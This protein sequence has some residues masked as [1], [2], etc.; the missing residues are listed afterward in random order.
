MPNTISSNPEGLTEKERNLGNISP[1]R[2]TTSLSAQ[3]VSQVT[4]TS[5]FSSSSAL[6]LQ[7][8]NESMTTISHLI[9]QPSLPGEEPRLTKEH[10]LRVLKYVEKMIDCIKN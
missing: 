9:V 5:T 3:R 2:S 4:S 1:S 10:L 7:S 6:Y 8:P